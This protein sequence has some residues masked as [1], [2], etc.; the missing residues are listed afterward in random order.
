MGLVITPQSKIDEYFEGDEISQSL[1]KCLLTG[2]D[3]FLQNRDDKGERQ[4]FYEEKG[5]WIIG[6][7][8]DMKLT[9][10]EGV[11]EEHYYCSDIE[12]KPS[13][14]EMSITQRVFDLIVTDFSEGNEDFNPDDLHNLEM[15]D[16][17]LE[18]SVV[19][20]DWYK[21][22][23]GPK[24]M[25]TLISNCELYFEDLKKSYGKQIIDVLQK[26][27]IDSIV[28]S[29]ATNS[30]TSHY[31]DREHHL[32]SSDIDV[33]LQVPIYFVYMGVDCKALLDMVIVFKDEDGK[34]THI[35]PFDLKTMAG[36]TV[37]FI[38]SVRTW[39]YDIQAAWYS[40]ALTNWYRQFDYAKECHITP[41]HFIVES[42]THIGT[43][44]VYKMSPSLLT[45]GKFGR[46]PIMLTETNFFDNP[47]DALDINGF[48]GHELVRE[49]R[50]YDSLMEEYLWYEE[51]G[52]DQDRI[53]P[54]S[55]DEVLEIE[56]NGIV[57]EE[58]ADSNR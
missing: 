49:I 44:L 26:Q 32:R 21:G 20:H 46:K 42:S 45:I 35:T 11:F 56:W 7:G 9:G 17:Y 58:N 5:S 41:F 14:T 25:N 37:D 16:T 51:H 36:K 48:S 53:I 18:T 40:L 27:T 3:K 52:W 4:L 57:N 43:P 55:A 28:A 13:D 12:K 10:Q 19:E 33:Y 15:Y 2:V 47:F 39:R 24:R 22:N 8:V 29:L 50:G 1:L 6:S 34:V 30:R 54:T 31:F 38:K 23:P